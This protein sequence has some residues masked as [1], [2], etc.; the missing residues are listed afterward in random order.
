MR[1]L[2]VLICFVPVMLCSAE[3]SAERF[4]IV[5]AETKLTYFE[6]GLSFGGNVC[7]HRQ[8]DL[9]LAGTLD[10]QIDP[11][12]HVA[13]FANVNVTLTGLAPPPVDD[14]W[15]QHLLEHKGPDLLSAE[16]VGNRV[17]LSGGYN[18]TAWDGDGIQ[19]EAVL[20]SMSIPEP[21]TVVQSSLGLITLVLLARR[22][23]RRRLAET[24]GPQASE[25]AA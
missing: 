22:T 23:V 5:P 25:R 6:G 3:V 15:F 20:Q 14:K 18:H 19:L 11:M 9:Q 12:T 1:S 16:V 13:T 2:Q 17:V 7:P 10:V 24:V 21:S 8:C 4:Q